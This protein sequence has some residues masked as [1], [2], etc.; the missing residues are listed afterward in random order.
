[1]RFGPYCNKH[2]REWSGILTASKMETATNEPYPGGLVNP[3]WHDEIVKPFGVCPGWNQKDR[4]Q[5][6]LGSAN[7]V[8]RFADPKPCGVTTIRGIHKNIHV[9]LAD[10]PRLFEAILLLGEE[11]WALC[12]LPGGARIKDELEMFVEPV[13]QPL[14]R[15]PFYRLATV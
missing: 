15:R 3:S 9:P 11:G 13:E 6:A 14:W 8:K 12:I 10:S 4:G 2:R 1:M 5:S 7:F